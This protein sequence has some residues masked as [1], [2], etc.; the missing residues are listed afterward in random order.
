MSCEGLKIQV[1]QKRNSVWL[2]LARNLARMCAAP[3]VHIRRLCQR[4]RVRTRDRCRPTWKFPAN[5]LP[6]CRFLQRIVSSTRRSD[7]L[8]PLAERCPFQRHQRWKASRSLQ[9]FFVRIAPPRCRT[10]RF[11][12]PRKSTYDFTNRRTWCVRGTSRRRLARRGHRNDERADTFCPSGLTLIEAK[13][14]FVVGP[15]GIITHRFDNIATDTELLDAIT[16]TLKAN[17]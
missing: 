4:Q 8:P 11:R 6:C 9:E 7:G 17:P 13:W 12:W 15:D 10:D 5:E 2:R 16:A 1:R 3:T 14:V